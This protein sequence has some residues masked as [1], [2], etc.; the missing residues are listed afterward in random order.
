M[1]DWLM[2]HAK[3]G[4]ILY[5]VC[6]R[7]LITIRFDSNFCLFYDQNKNLPVR[8]EINLTSVNKEAKLGFATFAP[9]EY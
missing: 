6:S 3:S 4:K 5:K 2:E 8:T 1:Y 9:T 7:R